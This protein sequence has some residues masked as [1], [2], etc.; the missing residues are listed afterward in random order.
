MDEPLP[1]LKLSIEEQLGIAQALEDAIA[2][3]NSAKVKFRGLEYTELVAEKLAIDPKQVVRRRVDRDSAIDAIA[4]KALGTLRA[5]VC[6]VRNGHHT[7][8]YALCRVLFEASLI[9]QWLL[10]EDTTVSNRRIDTYV[11]HFESAKVRADEVSK[12]MAS[13]AGASSPEPIADVRAREISKEVFDDKWFSWSWLSDGT[14]SGK[15]VAVKLAAMADELGLRTMFDMYYFDMSQYVHST[16]A[17]TLA[18]STGVFEIAPSPQEHLGRRALV[19]ANLCM[20]HLLG[21][22]NERYK[23]GIE[24]PLKLVQLKFLVGD[25][26]I[27]A[28]SAESSSGG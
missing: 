12:A 23:F 15:K 3:L 2:E 1:N 19:F 6:L 28:A 4:N 27:R 18:G 24:L 17:S 22:L 10:C 9:S 21:R 13:R 11:L 14:P 7:D 8:A 26:E 25:E 20:W 16:P 5:I